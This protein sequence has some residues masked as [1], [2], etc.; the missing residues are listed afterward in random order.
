[1]V[2]WCHV[3]VGSEVFLLRV[4]VE[5]KDGLRIQEEFLYLLVDITPCSVHCGG[6]LSQEG[7]VVLG[8]SVIYRWL[9]K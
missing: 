3:H 4:V 9:G 8:G 2:L 1:M 7:T 5:Q 6:V